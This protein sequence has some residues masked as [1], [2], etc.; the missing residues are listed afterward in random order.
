MQD[1]ILQ[2]LARYACCKRP[3]AP[4]FALLL[5][6]RFTYC[7]ECKYELSCTLNSVRC[8][9]EADEMSRSYFEIKFVKYRVVK[10][11]PYFVCIQ[12]FLF[13]NIFSRKLLNN[14]NFI[15]SGNSKLGIGGFTNGC[16]PKKVELQI[17]Y[18]TYSYIKCKIC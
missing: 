11:P 16:P 15:R 1:C 14:K 6:C 17:N 7:A 4:R 5:Y 10:K 8:S 18:L 3:A 13:L 2:C 9:K 12:P